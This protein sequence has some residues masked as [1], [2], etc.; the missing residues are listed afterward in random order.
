[1][2]YFAE[3]K[4]L[5]IHTAANESCRTEHF[6]AGAVFYTFITHTVCLT[7][8]Y[9]E[10][11]KNTRICMNAKANIPNLT[12]LSSVNAHED[13]SKLPQTKTGSAHIPVSQ[14]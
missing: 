3:S 12:T 7:R 14:P 13:Q 4:T 8:L 5:S 9:C 1:M 10:L 2:I 11:S 6:D